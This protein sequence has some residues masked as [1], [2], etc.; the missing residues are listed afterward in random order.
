MNGVAVTPEP[1]ARRMLLVERPCPGC[2]STDQSRVFAA[3]DM[4]PERL[5]AFAFSSRKLPEYMHHRLLECPRCDLLYASPLPQKEALGAAYEQAAFD[6]ATEAAFASRTYAELLA[7]RVLPRLPDRDGALDIGTGDGA[8]LHELL[9]CGFGAVAGVEPSRAPILAAH[10]K[11]RPLIRQGLFD[12]RDFQPASY[13]LIS[14]FQTL[15][16]VHDPLELCRQAH[17]LLREDGALLLVCHDR[18]ALSVRLL[19]L[20]SPIFDIEHLQ[21]FSA[22]SVRCL[23]ERSG[24]T[25]IEVLPIANR[26]PLHYWAKLFPFPAALKPALLGRLGSSRLGRRE[27]SLRAGNLAAIAY[28]RGAA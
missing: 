23:L 6:S 25:D 13:R 26:Y 2:G 19:G 10:P 17:S 15:E 14:C 16:H 12:V 3:A 22:R 4:D 11:V 18:R 1:P 5:D 28:K 27:I 24:F 9:A 7:R 21:L 8:F 20:R